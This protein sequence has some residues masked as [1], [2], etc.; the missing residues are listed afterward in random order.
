MLYPGNHDKINDRLRQ[1]IAEDRDGI[2]QARYLD[3]ER[4]PN[5][6]F[7]ALALGWLD[8]KSWEQMADFFEIST[9][10]RKFYYQNL[11]GLK[12]YL[13]KRLEE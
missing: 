1:I 3:R 5:V 7:Q 11:R 10:L 2:F 8:G 13:S 4:Y 9:G 12:N 6:N